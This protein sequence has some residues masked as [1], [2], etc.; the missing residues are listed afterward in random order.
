MLLFASA[1]ERFKLGVFDAH[2]LAF[3]DLVPAHCFV[4]LD[5]ALTDRTEQLI[6]HA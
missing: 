5:H 6:A 2:V 3:G 1:F 4:A